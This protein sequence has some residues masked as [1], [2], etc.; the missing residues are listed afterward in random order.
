MALQRVVP[1][2]ECALVLED[3]KQSSSRNCPHR[4]HQHDLDEGVESALCERAR[5][6]RYGHKRG[7]N[8]TDASKADLYRLRSPTRRASPTITSIAANSPRT[9]QLHTQ[10]LPSTQ[11]LEGHSKELPRDE[12]VV[13]N[14]A[15]AAA[16]D[17][18]D[19]GRSTAEI[20][21][22][23]TPGM[24]HAVRWL[25]TDAAERNSLTTRHQP[26]LVPHQSCRPI[27]A[28]LKHT[29]FEV[30]YAQAPSLPPRHENSSPAC[31]PLTSSSASPPEADCV[32]VA[33]P[34]AEGVRDGREEGVQEIE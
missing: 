31:L 16:A 19:T 17:I 24:N 11:A 28:E 6:G 9:L 12:S 23:R 7:H 10:P 2:C 33:A 34:A 1:F 3:V 5:S 32:Q 8:A 25:L 15:P 22:D 20:E 4:L 13:K 21:L 27:A 26:H 29:E 18:S 30:L 14:T